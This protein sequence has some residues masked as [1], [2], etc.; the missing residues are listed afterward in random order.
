MSS[1]KVRFKNAAKLLVGNKKFLSGLIMLFLIFMMSLSVYIFSIPYP[2]F[3]SVP[4]F[5]EPSKQFLLGTDGLGR[6]LFAV[7]LYGI[8]T[9]FY[10]GFMAG[11]LSTALGVLI[12][13]LGG[14]KGG[15]LDDVLRSVIDLFLVIP[16]WPI[17]VLI[18]V[19]VKS[20][21]IPVMAFLLTAFSWQGSARAIRSQV[22]SLKERE[23]INIA[24]LSGLGTFEI[25][26]EEIFPNMISYIAASFV[27]SVTGVILTEASLEVIGLGPPSATSLGLMLFW[28]QQ[29]GAIVKGWWWWILPPISVLVV[30]F[31]S[32]ILL[33]LGLDEIS[34]PRLRKT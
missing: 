6:D 8:Q 23:F 1:I 31:I 15:L 21:T 17:L 16:V 24:R 9:S 11:T 2:T 20:L 19:S 13:F 34:N 5:R 27:M 18:S 7:L 4:A 33:T 10:I 32:L 3:G 28:S 30:L 14:Y 26:F 29:Y 22:M 25:L 12:G